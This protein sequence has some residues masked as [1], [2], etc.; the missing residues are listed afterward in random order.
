[1][2]ISLPFVIGQILCT[3]DGQLSGNA[4]LPRCV[5]FL[6]CGASGTRFNIVLGRPVDPGCPGGP[7]AIAVNPKSKDLMNNFAFSFVVGWPE[8]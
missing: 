6:A 3:F 5:V 7:G 8:M 1:M 4:F 2:A